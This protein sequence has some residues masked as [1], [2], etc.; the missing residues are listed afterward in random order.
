MRENCIF[1]LLFGFCR[2][3]NQLANFQWL[4]C[5]AN[6]FHELNRI[7]L[8]KWKENYS[9]HALSQ[10]ERQPKLA[11]KKPSGDKYKQFSHFPSIFFSF[12]IIRWIISVVSFDERLSLAISK[13]T[14]SPC[15]LE[16]AFFY[17]FRYK[18]IWVMRIRNIAIELSRNAMA[19]L[20]LH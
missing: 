15:A 11:K 12:F 5:K 3:Q 6:Q 19:D 16:R 9:I 17:D 4:F 8:F 1:D 13:I 10:I 20:C 14:F 2:T 7:L 18:K